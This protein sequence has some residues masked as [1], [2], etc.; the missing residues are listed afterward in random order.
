VSVSR[1]VPSRTGGTAP[2]V[3]R[4]I[5]AFWFALAVLAL[6]VGSSAFGPLVTGVPGSAAVAAPVH[7]SAVPATSYGDL[8]VTSGQTVTLQGPG[9]G[10]TYYQEGNITVEA[11]GT[12]IVKNT[13]ISFVQYTTEGGTVGQEFA[14]LYHF[15]DAGTV[16]F[17]NAGLTTDVNVLNFSAKLFVAISGVLNAWNS[18]FEFPGWIAVSGPQAQA[19]FN[20]S[21]IEGNPGVQAI[22][23]ETLVPTQPYLLTNDTDYAP[24]LNVTAGGELNLFGSTYAGTYANN[25]TQSGAPPSYPIVETA[26]TVPQAGASFALPSFNLNGPTNSW[27]VTEA[28][29]YPSVTSSVVVTVNFGS[30]TGI[31][32]VNLTYNG[33]SYHLGNI[34]WSASTSP[35]TF[36]QGPSSALVQALQT[37]G[38]PLYT[39]GVVSFSRFTSTTTVP[40]SSISVQIA[41]QFDFGI[42]VSGAS[43]QLSTVDTSLDLNFQPSF[44]NF[45][46]GS[47]LYPWDS[48]KLVVNNGASAFLGNL[49][50]PNA[51]PSNFSAS[52]V[53]PDGASTV[54]LYRWAEFNLL[55]EDDIHVAGAAVSAD[56]AYPAPN[57]NN[58]TANTANDF[59][60]TDPAIWA[61]LHY[62]D[63]VRGIPAYG[64][65]GDFGDAY[66]LLASN[67]LN[68]SNL[69]NGNFLG[70]Y[71]IGISVPGLAPVWAYAGVSP[72][73][74]GVA[75]NSPGYGLPDVQPT[76]TITGY[77]GA[78][79]LETPVILANGTLAPSATVREGQ[80]LGVQVTLTDEGTAKI[81]NVN[82]TL[83]WNSTLVHGGLFN[84]TSNTVDLTAPG[85]KTTFNLTWVV[86]DTITGLHGNFTNAFF[87]ALS[88]NFGLAQLAGGLLSQ[89]ATV[90]IAPSQIGLHDLVPPTSPIN[91]NNQYF[92]TGV[93]T[94]N[95]S[96]EAS[97]FVTATPVGGGQSVQVGSGASGPGKFEVFWTYPLSSL[98]T[99]GTTYTLTV[100]A[101]YNQ[102]TVTAALPGTYSVPSTTSTTGFLYEKFLGLPL[103]LW[104]VIAAAIVVAIVAVLLI[105]RRQAAGKLVECGECGELIPEDATVCPKC[106]A[107]FESDLVRCS[108][109]SSTIPANSQFCPE[110]GAQLL[111]KPGEGAS[112]PE[113]Q[114]YADFTERFRTEA[115]KELG[116]NFT[117]SAFWDWWKRQPSYVP[118]SQ[119]QAQQA[120]GTPRAGMS[121]PPAGSQVAAPESTGPGSPPSGGMAA[122]PAA[123]APAPAP[124]PMAPPPA[125]PA[126][127]PA[128]GLKPCPSC[129]KEIPPEYLVCPFCGAVTQ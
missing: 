124:A 111:G 43:S 80:E 23:N 85:Q 91:L 57:Y 1:P 87:V 27:E 72:Y 2:R 116:D 54:I 99:P 113:R 19:T 11:G 16:N 5:V 95:G 20:N 88:W 31:S 48:H 89:T 123:A 93:I 77:F 30:A 46:T 128:G 78:A 129:G 96:S 37:S 115:K 25:L 118:F 70:A 40:V 100:T 44:Y 110:C 119:W 6:M 9:S 67:V 58:A 21:V 68:G 18:S 84:F 4:S 22:R 61:Y 69:P 24:S 10:G 29:L 105:F 97:I 32:E 126:A 64:V 81:F 59:A 50:I 101:T 17:T 103:W 49:T 66:L 26:L 104:L 109:C 7:P 108:R 79:V 62:W 90:T 122:G 14:H 35:V 33:V 121:Q 38:I 53:Q 75:L 52:A 65:S 47:I 8:V 127:S 83:F 63:A 76:T 3:R 92:T 120:S 71:H 86:N 12:L 82:A 60:T 42:G 125:A 13:T 55:G 98:L 106:G 56:Y 73:P 94:Y 36:T 114:A 74:A 51:L 34:N 45:T 39:T 107:E 41:P 102:G 15:T 112:D 28:A 117:E